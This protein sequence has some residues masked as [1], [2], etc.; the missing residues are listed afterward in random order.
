MHYVIVAQEQLAKI[1]SDLNMRTDKNILY[2]ASQLQ[3]YLTYPLSNETIALLADT[4]QNLEQ[5]MMS[6]QERGTTTSHMKVKKSGN[7]Y[8]PTEGQDIEAP[9]YNVPILNSRASMRDASDPF[10]HMQESNMYPSN[11]GS[12][13]IFMLAF[14]SFFFETLFLILSFFLYRS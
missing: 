6:Y 10:L 11:R 9:N 13:N 14:I 8:I 3:T 7:F 4:L 12:S 1:A 2:I 5:H